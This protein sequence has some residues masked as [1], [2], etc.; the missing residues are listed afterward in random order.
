MDLGC[1]ISTSGVMPFV[2][3]PALT[4][5]YVHLKQGQRLKLVNPHGNQV[6]DF[7][8]FVFPNT[9]TTAQTTTFVR[10]SQLSTRPPTT[11]SYPFTTP[12]QYFSASRTRSVLS[13]L[14]PSATTHDILYTNKSLRLL[15]LIEDTTTG[16]HD[17][18][19][20][21]CDRF[22]YHN[23][24][25]DDYEHGSCSENM[26]LALRKAAADGVIPKGAI[27][28]DWTPDPLNVFMNVAVTTGLGREDGGGKMENRVPE[29]KAGEYIVLR[30]EVDCVAVMS[31]CPNDV[32]EAVNGGKC[33]GVEYEVL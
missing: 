12:I 24:G 28:E 27:S 6:I 3:I 23:L 14:I 25:V 19:Y 21:C 10:S 16:I 18:L 32:I 5:D 7:W 30:A 33:T 15:T 31:A 1:Q 17:T 2:T 4:G 26:H 29:S 11:A 13:K 20:G 8:A 9:A 22:R